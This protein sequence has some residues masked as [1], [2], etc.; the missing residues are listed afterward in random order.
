MMDALNG[1]NSLS[2][3]P[4]GI[5]SGNERKLS[6]MQ[7]WVRRGFFTISFLLCVVA[8]TREPE[9]ETISA[10]DLEAPVSSREVRAAFYF[11]SVDQQRTQEARDAAMVKVP[12]HLRVD[13]GVLND[14]A[15]ILRERIS[16]IREYRAKVQEVVVTALRESTQDQ[17]AWLTA[18]R[19]VTALVAQL[20]QRAEGKSLPDAEVMVQWLLPDRNSLPE[21]VFEP[22]K[23]AAKQGDSPQPLKVSGLKPDTPDPL[24]FTE[25]DR[26]GTLAM[27]ELQTAL[28]GGIRAGDLSADQRR[29]KVV[30]LGAAVGENAPAPNEIEYGAAPDPQEATAALGARLADMASAPGPSGSAPVDWT[31]IREAVVG[32]VQPLLVPTLV[33]D[34]VATVSAKARAAES[35]PA[36]MKEVEAGEIIQDR[37]KRW[38]RQSRSDVEA[39]LSIVRQEERPLQRMIN[40]LIAHGILVLLAFLGLYRGCRLLAGD[41]AGVRPGIGGHKAFEVSLV[42]ACLVLVSGRLASYFEPTGFVVP[43]A[44]A[45]ILCAILVN[46]P[47]AAFFSGITATLVSAQ[48]QYNWRLMLVASAMSAA[49]AFSVSR[50]RRRSDMTAAS[51]VAA[52]A[53]VAA[54]I[55]V[56]L[57]TESLF[58]ESFLRRVLLV[59]LNGGFCI[60][61]VP[62]LLSPLERLFGLTTDITLL[63]YSDLNNQLL[64]ELAMKAP[65][66]YAHSLLL[67]QLAEAAADAIGANGLLAR[68][69]GYY[70]DV[71]KTIDAAMFVENQ[72]GVNVHDSLPPEKSVAL[73]RQHVIYGAELARKYR[74]PEAIVRGIL[75]H[76]GTLRVGYFYQ[77][78]VERYGIENVREEEYRYPGPRPQ[79]PETAILMICDAS[80][81]GVRTLDAPTEENVHAFVRRVMDMRVNDGQFDECNLTLRQLHVIEDVVVRGVMGTL[82]ARIRYPN[83]TAAPVLVLAAAKPMEGK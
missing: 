69:C 22:Q 53:G 42:L 57:S 52:M 19:A 64:S 3:V 66:T 28:G 75:E 40:N 11:E 24:T 39:Y 12:D 41:P 10:A 79:R 20:K 61:A 45:A 46:A 4:G 38:T 50:V 27:E 74:L 5:S 18:E 54:M 15:R 35:I 31:R 2:S 25:S 23:D 33:E 70:H 48:F 6:T 83:L 21:R 68:V 17:D 59:V 47:F 65:A 8:L 43:V 9:Q 80:E 71:G 82:H 37:G 67:G 56:I 63:E 16:Q 55:A 32:M 7:R 44:A 49:G 30:I 77:Q 78:A 62:G 34:K 81:S 58:A 1:T 73:I 14:Q 72:Q 76:H 36:A 51:L 29:R 60:V 26:L 13:M